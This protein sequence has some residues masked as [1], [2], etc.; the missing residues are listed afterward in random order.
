MLGKLVRYSDS[1]W[2]AEKLTGRST[3]GFA[4]QRRHHTIDAGSASQQT[5][6]VRSAEVEFYASG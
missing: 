4:A 5:I 6:T 3:T 1:D 2:A